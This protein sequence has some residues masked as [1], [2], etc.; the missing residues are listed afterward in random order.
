[1]KELTKQ[2]S[3]I[4]QNFNLIFT[5]WRLENKSFFQNNRNKAEKQ[6]KQNSNF[7]TELEMS[8]YQQIE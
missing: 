8:S 4:I 1:M 2:T 7:C 3:Q 5:E 6:D